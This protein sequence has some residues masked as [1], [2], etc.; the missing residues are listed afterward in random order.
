MNESESKVCV[1]NSHGR[2]I[3]STKLFARALSVKQEDIEWRYF[4]SY[5]RN[6]DDWKSF[7]DKLSVEISFSI[8]TRLRN[9]HRRSYR[10]ILNCKKIDENRYSVEM[11]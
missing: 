8:D 4:I 3:E 7:K 11:V 1:I 6:E 2:F 9:K 5:F 10:A